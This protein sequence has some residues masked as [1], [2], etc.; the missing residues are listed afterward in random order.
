MKERESRRLR[1][2]SEF[3]DV[4]GSFVLTVN[5]HPIPLFVE[6]IPPKTV[7]ISGLRM[8]KLHHT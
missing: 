5:E 1:A 3:L 7:T 2:P 8:Q 4:L 6:K